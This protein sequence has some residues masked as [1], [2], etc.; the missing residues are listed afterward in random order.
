MAVVTSKA[1]YYINEE[2]LIKP[3]KT[4]R[5]I[6][7]IENACD[8]LNLTHNIELL[9]SDVIKYLVDYTCIYVHE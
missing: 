1:T 2:T 3:L 6:T 7:K 8:V 9:G 4:V 5:D